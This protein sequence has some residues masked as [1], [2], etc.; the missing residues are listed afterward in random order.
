MFQFI[1]AIENA[2]VIKTKG[3]DT[4]DP[5]QVSKLL[6]M[7]LVPESEREGGSTKGFHEVKDGMPVKNKFLHSSEKQL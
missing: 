6:V 3:S 4:C 5:P 7:P 2:F 1:V